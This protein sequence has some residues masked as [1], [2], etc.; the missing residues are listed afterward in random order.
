MLALLAGLFSC[1]GGEEDLL[2]H[3]EIVVNGY[4]PYVEDARI[5]DEVYAGEITFYTIVVDMPNAEHLLAGQPEKALLRAGYPTGTGF[6][7]D[8]ILPEPPG[9]AI[10]KDF[11]GKALFLQPGEQTLYILSAPTPEQGGMPG[12]YETVGS[13]GPI[14]QGLI[15]REFP[16]TVL[17]AR[18]TEE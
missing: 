8:V 15:Y 9:G 14:T 3:G 13:P 6:V 11:T 2:T 10:R 5:P 12:K 4:F 1:G 16:V 17:P 7:I 18:E